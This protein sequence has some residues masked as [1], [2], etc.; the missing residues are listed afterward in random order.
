MYIQTSC[1]IDS[2]NNS[3][4]S[5]ISGMWANQT[6]VCGI[7]QKSTLT[8]GYLRAC[9]DGL[10]RIESLFGDTCPKFLDILIPDDDIAQ[11]FRSQKKPSKILHGD[12]DELWNEYF[13]RSAG[14]SVRFV[15]KPSDSE[16]LTAI[17]KWQC[18]PPI[19]VE[20]PISL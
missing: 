13:R 4:Y 8:R 16:H 6:A 7:E 11:Q 10:V 9:V 12:N 18:V 20:I 17:L 3:F 15:T 14:Y 19:P 1:F 2:N 5:S